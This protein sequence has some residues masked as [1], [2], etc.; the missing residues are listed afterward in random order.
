M[1]ILALGAVMGGKLRANDMAIDYPRKGGCQMK[2]A[3]TL[4]APAFVA[5]R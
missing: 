1:R 3:G 4:W 2:K 5:A